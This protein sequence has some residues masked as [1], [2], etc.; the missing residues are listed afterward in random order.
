[1]PFLTDNFTEAADTNLPSHTADLGSGTWHGISRT[2]VVIGSEDRVRGDSDTG[3]SSAYHDASPA[4]AEYDIDCILRHTGASSFP[5]MGVMARYDAGTNNYL[6]CFVSPSQ[7]DLQEI[8]GGVAIETV[9]TSATFSSGT[10][11]VTKLVVRN[12]TNGIK[13]FVGGTLRCQLTADVVTGAGKVGVRSRIYGRVD[14]L[15]A[16]DYVTAVDLTIA[17]AAHAHSADNLALTQTHVLAVAD[18]AHAHSAD[19][20]GLTTATALAIADA[21]HAH[22]SDNLTLTQTHVLAIQEAVH[23]HAADQITLSVGGTDLVIADALHAHGVD[24][25]ALTQTHVLVVSDA[26]H[27]HLAD[28]LSLSIPGALVTDS[29]RVLVVR[30]EARTLV[31]LRESRVLTVPVEARS[32][33]VH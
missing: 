13:L 32:L 33:R 21:L 3:T 18:A 28:V 27:A 17:D 26:L 14:S 30:G 4:G 12:G 6:Q 2:M 22:A 7:V 1:M 31:I 16:T 25:L 23:A 19:Q 29:D 11:H 10:D 20:V 8:S 5:G 9:T 15:V 24:N